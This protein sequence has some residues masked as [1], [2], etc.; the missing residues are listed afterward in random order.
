ME[1]DKQVEVTPFEL[2]NLKSLS[3][4]NL[5]SVC[6]LKVNVGV[7]FPVLIIYLFLFFYIQLLMIK[8]SKEMRDIE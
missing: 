1:K 5:R 8:Y 6:F 4:E 7:S 2:S 3:L